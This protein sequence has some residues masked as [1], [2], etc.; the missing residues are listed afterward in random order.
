MYIGAAEEAG[1]MEG[2]V[3]ALAMGAYPL[4]RCSDL[5]MT[6]AFAAEVVKGVQIRIWSCYSCE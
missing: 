5:D 6:A 1:Y 2:A 4:H 3:L